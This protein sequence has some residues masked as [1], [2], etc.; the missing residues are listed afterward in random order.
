M[1]SPVMTTGHA[2]GRGKLRVYRWIPSR[3]G[4]RGWLAAAAV[5]D[6]LMLGPG[7]CT[8]VEGGPLC[9]FRS[10]WIAGARA[11][12]Y[13]FGPSWAACH[14]LFELAPSRG[15]AKTIGVVTEDAD[16]NSVNAAG[17]EDRLSAAC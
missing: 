5:A 3:T 2:F 11:R 7:H 13:M 14:L 10:P 9:S 4:R 16:T 6:V 17:E 15:L 8:A 1:L 12:S